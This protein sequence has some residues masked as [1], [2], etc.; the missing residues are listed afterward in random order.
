MCSSSAL[1]VRRPAL[2]PFLEGAAPSVQARGTK[3]FRWIIPTAPRRTRTGGETG[4]EMLKT[5][6]GFAG[7]R[8]W[9]VDDQ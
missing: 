2:V 3:E 1:G 9:R 8:L 4:G 7:G 6:E 5:N